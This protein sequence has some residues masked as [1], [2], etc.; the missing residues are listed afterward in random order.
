MV[1]QNWIKALNTRLS[2]TPNIGAKVGY[3]ALIFSTGAL[4]AAGYVIVGVC[5][6]AVF[7]ATSMLSNLWNAK[8]EDLRPQK[9]ESDPYL[10]DPLPGDLSPWSNGHYRPEYEELMR[11][12]K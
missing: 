3:G 6:G 7:L 1:A 8:G 4:V 12:Q 9:I 2:E 10:T 11:H 5:K